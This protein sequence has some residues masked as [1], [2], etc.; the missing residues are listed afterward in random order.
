MVIPV[1]LKPAESVTAFPAFAF[2]LF[3][4]TIESSALSDDTG[5][6]T[7]TAVVDDTV[8][9]VLADALEAEDAALAFTMIFSVNSPPSN[10]E[11]S[12]DA[13]LNVS[14]YVPVVVGAFS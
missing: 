9:D 10:Q 2:T 6:D 3:A 7:A 5:V 12:S 8:A 11:Y 13:N 14:A 1:F 4:E